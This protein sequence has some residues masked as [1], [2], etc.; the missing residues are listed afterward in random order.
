MYE[1]VEIP[2]RAAVAGEVVALPIRILQIIPDY[3]SAEDKKGYQPF[4]VVG[5]ISS[6]LGHFGWRRATQVLKPTIWAPAISDAWLRDFLRSD[7]FSHEVPIDEV[8]KRTPH[9]RQFPGGKRRPRRGFEIVHA[10]AGVYI[11]G[12]NDKP[13]LLLRD[14]PRLRLRPGE[15]RDLLVQWGTRLVVL[16]VPHYTINT[17]TFAR[18]VVGGG[19]PVVLLVRKGNAVLRS[20][21]FVSLYANIVHNYPLREIADKAPSAGI[22]VTLFHGE[23]ADGILQLE[24]WMDILQQTLSISSLKDVSIKDLRWPMEAP[25]EAH[26]GALLHR[27]QREE[28]EQ[29]IGSRLGQ[30]SGLLEQARDRIQ[31]HEGEGVIP[32]LEVERETKKIERD[33][34]SV[35]WDHASRAPRVLNANFADPQARRML[36]PRSAIVA[37]QTYDLLVDIGPRWNV[38][39]SI[40]L[41]QAEFPEYALPPGENGYQIQVIFSSDDFK[42]PISSA[43]L[44]LPANTGRSSPI[45]EGKMMDRP[46]PVAIHVVAPTFD[47]QD[48]RQVKVARGR[49]CLYYENNLLQSARVSVGVARSEKV[50]LD[51]DNAIFV[52]YLI[53]STF[54]NL[55]DNFAQRHIGK[56]RLPVAVNLTLNDDG[57]GGH[58]ILVKNIDDPAPAWVAYDPQAMDNLLGDARAELLNIYYQR[59]LNGSPRSTK[60][61]DKKN[62]KTREQFRLDLYV[63]ATLGSRL[64]NA[65][66]TQATPGKAGQRTISWV[67]GI[68][69]QLYQ[70]AIIQVARKESTPSQYVFPW[71]LIYDYPLPG[72]SSELRYCKIIKEEWSENGIRKTLPADQCPYQDDRDHQENVLCPYG[73]WGLKHILELPLSALCKDPVN[74]GSYQ[75]VEATK[76]FSLHQAHPEVALGVTE[77]RNLD[78]SAI[79]DHV[80]KVAT[81]I[82]SRLA[83]PNPAKDRKSV[84][85]VVANAGIVYF[86]CHGKYDPGERSPYLGLGPNTSDSSLFVYPK[87]IQEWAWSTIAPN[88]EQW[89]T[90]R[91]L[92]IINGCH[93]CQLKPGEILNFVNAFATAQASGVIGTE[94]SMQLPVAIEVAERL[95]SKI[96]KS[97]P[98]GLGAAMREVRWEMANKG[99]LLGLAYTLHALADLQ[100]VR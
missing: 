52:D 95:I 53:T 97:P 23:G 27:S 70:K 49:L 68:R 14:K 55:E 66:V 85:E 8:I 62:G 5:A 92:V 77:D 35:S 22:E 91:P 25:I 46:G 34:K 81:L 36:E 67:R 30:A 9:L 24:R 39:K 87:N 60:A 1:I 10:V 51:E 98:V 89:A 26:L 63:L 69:K 96:A 38:H 90:S 6:I 75:L 79:H 21:F 13:F 72:P 54:Q 17:E 2:V 41:G 80:E 61:L 71:A 43:E 82:G 94:I 4:N 20:D 16:E 37:G 28:I 74:P 88:L 73:F 64:F 11:E 57:A 15:A 76:Y 84:R 42:P 86:L 31:Y 29:K 83:P 65:V 45:I 59:N 40:V 19:G 48:D 3:I 12:S 58:R 78:I 33:L 100:M 99:N 32:L 56:T 47:K 50:R 18:Y 44:W 7:P 93:T